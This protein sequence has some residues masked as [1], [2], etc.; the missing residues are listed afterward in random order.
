MLGW[1]AVE[2]PFLWAS[3]ASAP[4][5]HRKHWAVQHILSGSGSALWLEA[6]DLASALLRDNLPILIPA[7]AGLFATRA[8]DR[9]LS[10]LLALAAACLAYVICEILFLGG[11]LYQAGFFPGFNFTRVYIVFPFLCITAGSLGLAHIPAPW[12]V[13]LA[14]VPGEPPALALRSLL[15]IVLIGLAGW[16]S[17]AI[18]REAIMGIADG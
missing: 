8:R 12:Q 17:L 5:G 1:L 11:L 3:A 14:G 13:R 18:K 9:R 15:C 4:F 10:V 16:Q 7:V 2:A 6:V